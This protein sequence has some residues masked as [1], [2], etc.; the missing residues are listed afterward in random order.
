[1]FDVMTK[2]E[3]PNDALKQPPPI[4]WGHGEDSGFCPHYNRQPLPHPWSKQAVLQQ[5]ELQKATLFP[6]GIFKFKLR[7][8]INRPI[9]FSQPLSAG[10]A[11]GLSH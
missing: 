6:P 8:Q 10:G 7:I 11:L 2:W 5:L 3:S 4:L 9:K 1:M